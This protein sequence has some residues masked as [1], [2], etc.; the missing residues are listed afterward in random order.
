MHS[1]TSKLKTTKT[2]DLKIKPFSPFLQ[3][4]PSSPLKM[5]LKGL[6]DDNLKAEVIELK[7]ETFW[8]FK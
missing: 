8:N 7:R 4:A 5:L 3:S 2:F 1:E 6:K